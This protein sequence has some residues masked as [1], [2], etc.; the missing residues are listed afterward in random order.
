MFPRLRGLKTRL[1]EA[2]QVTPTVAGRTAFLAAH[3]WSR[4]SSRA[5]MALP[6]FEVSIPVSLRGRRATLTVRSNASDSGILRG[7]FRDLEYDYPDTTPVRRVLDLGGNVGYA[8]VFFS[9]RFPGVEVLA[10]EPMADNARL[11]RANFA[12]NGVRGQVIEAAVATTDGTAELLLADHDGCHSLVPLHGA[13][14]RTVTVPCLSVETLLTRAG[15]DGV[16]LLKVDIE[17]YEEQLFAGSPA[18]LRK[19]KVIV[20]E[21]HGAYGLT[22]FQRD[23]AP[24]GF[25]VEVLSD[26]YERTVIARRPA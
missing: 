1:T 23:V 22:E 6:R 21:L 15:W 4:L 16:D 11:C 8:A 7:V 10:V 19:V 26:A 3:Y 14:G 20:G 2:W 18:W 25:R 12:R 5:P 17:G 13:S 9:L 24:A